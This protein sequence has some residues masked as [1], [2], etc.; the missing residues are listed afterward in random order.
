MIEL[1]LTNSTGSELS[2][3]Q[4][5]E[6]RLGDKVNL[7]LLKQVVLMYEANQ[8]QGTVKTKRRSEQA[9]STRKLYRQKGTGR[10]RAGMLRTP[11][12]RGGGKA[13]GPEPR[14]FSYSMPRKARQLARRS[15]LLAKLQDHEVLLVDS[16]QLE[17]LK[18]K[19]AIKLLA[20]LGVSGTA[21]LV[22][23][24]YSPNLYLA[25]RNLP[26]VTVKPVAELSAY[27]LLKPKV[28]VMEQ[29]ALE[30]LMGQNQ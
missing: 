12:R 15:A 25:T 1:S 21:T 11:T 9:G 19:G 14:D 18:T 3:V 4:V 7:K 13:F 17:G 24:Q 26:G 22:P 5:D 23:N 20:G 27:D 8:R 29:A 10:A 30:N 6:S 28:V 16:L 2:K